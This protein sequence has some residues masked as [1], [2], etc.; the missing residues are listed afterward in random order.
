[1]I[2]KKIINKIKNIKQKEAKYPN[3]ELK[4]VLDVLDS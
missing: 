2:E 3:N 1:M 4:Y